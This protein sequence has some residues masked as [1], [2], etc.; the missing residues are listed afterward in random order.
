D[1]KIP[2]ECPP[3]GK[4]NALVDNIG[5]K[6]RRSPFEADLHR[7]HDRVYRLGECIPDLVGVDLVGLGNS[8][9]EIPSF[10]LHGAYCS[11]R[12]S[13][14]QFDLYRLSLLIADKKVVFSFYVLDDSLVHL[15]AAD[16]YGLGIDDSR[17]RNDR[18][19]RSPAP[20]IDYH[21]A[22]CLGNRE[23]CPNCG[24]HRLLDKIDF[25][26]AG[27]LCRLLDRT[28]LHLGYAGRDADD[29]PRPYQSLSVMHLVNKVPEHL[30]GN[31]EV[32][33]HPVLHGTDS[34]DIARGTAEHLLCFHPYGKNLL[35]AVIQLLYGHDR[36]FTDHDPLPFQV[37]ESIG[38]A[39]VDRKVIGKHSKEV[40]EYFKHMMLCSFAIYRI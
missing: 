28:F 12:V 40:I 9:N 18:H 4:E 16:T 34:G 27:R 14:A 22:G 23:S 6:F 26:G 8:G 38:R 37:D 39:Q 3:A 24:S 10:Y 30:F 29:Y 2:K 33:D 31:V 17:E 20:D 7:I 21:I 19:L 35:L 25:P 15:V 5:C 1:V 11:A 13:L 36:R 32:C